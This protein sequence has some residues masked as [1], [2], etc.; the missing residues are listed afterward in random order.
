MNT[1][2]TKIIEDDFKMDEE[3][4]EEESKST[5]PR[6]HDPDLGFIGDKTDVED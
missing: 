2:L 3:L 5:L 4:P 6:R 1:W